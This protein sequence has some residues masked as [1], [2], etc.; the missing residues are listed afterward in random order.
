MDRSQ[1]RAVRILFTKLRDRRKEFLLR[2]LTK[3]IFS[4][5]SSDLPHFFRDRRV[6]R[7]QI[8]VAATAVDDAQR[9]AGIREFIVE[10]FDLRI[11]LV[12]K[13]DGDDPADGAGHL[14]HQTAGLAEVDVFRILADLRDLD[15]RKPVFAV[16]MIDDIADKRFEGG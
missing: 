2:N 7:R 16:H 11:I 9:V 14:V 8:L 10:L 3:H 5:V 6:I 4:E 15:R 12:L 13:I 1:N